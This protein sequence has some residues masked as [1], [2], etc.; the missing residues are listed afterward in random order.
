MPKKREKKNPKITVQKS[1]QVLF[2]IASTNVLRLR[3]LL[4]NSTNYPNPKK[5]YLESIF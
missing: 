1:S 4:R 2:L 3:H 5:R